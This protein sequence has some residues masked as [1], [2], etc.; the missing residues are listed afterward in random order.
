MKS[1]L[2]DSEAERL[3]EKAIQELGVKWDF[4]PEA[5]VLV[6]Q[7]C[8][9]KHPEWYHDLRA[10]QSALLAVLCLLLGPIV[11]GYLSI[12]SSKD[13]SYQ[14][15]IKAILNEE[16]CI[17]KTPTAIR[18]AAAPLQNCHSI[19]EGLNPISIVDNLS[20][21]EFLSR[22]A[23]SGRPVLVRGATRDWS[24]K[25]QFSFDY[26]KRIFQ[27]HAES[28]VEHDNSSTKAQTPSEDN[29]DLEM[30]Q[31]FPYRTGFNDLASFFNIS[32]ARSRLDSS[33]KSYYVGWNNCFSPTI[34]EIRRHY[35]RPAFLP[36]DAET[37]DMDWI[38]MGGSSAENGGGAPTHID[39]VDRPSWQAVVSGAKT[40]SLYPP[41]ECENVCEPVLKADM[42]AGDILVV[43][44]NIW[45]HGTKA[46]KGVVTIAIGSE[47]D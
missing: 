23:Y 31:F 45:Y 13:W 4:R 11:L 29:D 25:D 43:D 26:F 15:A 8:L 17:V 22:Y 30:C 46:E 40:W 44:T 16:E 33:E 7:S 41:P 18:F 12:F 38:F 39:Q 19:C 27:S 28:L 20:P 10:I 34:A 32:E 35:S 24:A 47:F 14:H 36:K 1:K 3:L 2:S 42:L 9:S 21:E 6:E 5:A 37:A